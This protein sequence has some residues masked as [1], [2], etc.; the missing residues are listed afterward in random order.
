MDTNF[1]SENLI[2]EIDNHPA[3][4]VSTCSEYS[5]RHI[6][7]KCWE[8]LTDIF[9]CDDNTLQENKKFVNIIIK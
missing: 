2:I 3:I 6:K 8:E 1:D 9:S 5:N 4:W 7:N